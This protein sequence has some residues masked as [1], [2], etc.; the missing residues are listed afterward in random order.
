MCALVAQTLPLLQGTCRRLDTFG[1]AHAIDSLIV[2][3]RDFDFEER[4]LLTYGQVIEHVVLC[5]YF[6]CHS[7]DGGQEQAISHRAAGEGGRGCI[8]GI[9][10]MQVVH[11]LAQSPP[12]L[13]I[14]EDEDLRQLLVVLK[15]V[16]GLEKPFVAV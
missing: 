4:K 5:H 1:V 8:H 12:N 13:V 2:N 9:I 14:I 15:F 3:L 10:A 16:E 7:Q 11:A 6:E